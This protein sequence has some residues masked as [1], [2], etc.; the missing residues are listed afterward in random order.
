M[1]SSQNSRPKFNSTAL[2]N[3]MAETGD[4]LAGFQQSLDRVSDDI[5]ALETFLTKSG[6]NLPVRLEV[7]ENILGLQD[8]GGGFLP[9]DVDGCPIE[10]EREYLVWDKDQNEKFRLQYQH[11]IHEGCMDL[12]GGGNKP[13]RVQAI[14]RESEVRPLIE[15]KLDVRIS[16]LE[17]LPKFIAE[18]Q[19]RLRPFSDLKNQPS[20]A[21]QLEKLAQVVDWKE[22]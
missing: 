11:S 13:Y 1:T 9:E 15:C 19:R 18:F 12:D 10:I 6:I 2:S 20:M 7:G 4:T 14:P 22:I 16:M 21:E 5:K 3:A 8:F 17:Q